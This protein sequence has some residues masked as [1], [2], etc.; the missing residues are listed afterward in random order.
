MDKEFALKILKRLVRED[1][2]VLVHRRAKYARTVSNEA[3][4]II[5]A[6]LTIIL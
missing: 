4:K 1:K 2:F 5:V 3:A 6:Q